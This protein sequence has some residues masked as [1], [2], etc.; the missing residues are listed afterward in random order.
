MASIDIVANLIRNGTTYKKN[1]QMQ[2]DKMNALEAS[3]YQGADPHFTYNVLSVNLP[4]INNFVL[5]RDHMQ[6]IYNIDAVTG[7]LRIFLIVSDP[8]PGTLTGHWQWV[9]TRMR[10]S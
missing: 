6:D 8:M 9:C 3:E 1:V 5:Y 2:L 7:Q 4:V 10:G